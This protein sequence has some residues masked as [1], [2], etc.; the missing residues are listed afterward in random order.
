MRF[1]LIVNTMFKYAMREGVITVNNPTIWRVILSIEDATMAYVRAV[2][3]NYK[4][5]GPFNI[6]SGNYTVGEVADL[7]R[8][9]VERA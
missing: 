9:H 6:A 4:L 2:E 3:A 1:D 7:V 5:S 8:E